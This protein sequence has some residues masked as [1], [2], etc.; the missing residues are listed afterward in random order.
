M[1]KKGTVMIIDD[2]PIVRDGLAYFI[3]RNPYLEVVATAEDGEA[4]QRTIAQLPT[5]PDV[6]VVDLKMP[7]INGVTFIKRVR[8]KTKIVVYSSCINFDIAAHM[9]QYGVHGYLL[10]REN[11]QTIIEALVKVI[12]EDYYMALSDEVTE[13]N[14]CVSDRKNTF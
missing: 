10:K 5:L 8:P 11:S 1:I 13:K 4:A 3:G 12:N 7:K 14:G 2:Q 9:P 6:I